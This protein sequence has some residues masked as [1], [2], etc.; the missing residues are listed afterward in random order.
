MQNRKK[1]VIIAQRYGITP[2][3]FGGAVESLIGSL[4]E[5]N[6]IHHAIDLTIIQSYNA[7]A[8]ELTKKFKDTKFVFLRDSILGKLD[9]RIFGQRKNEEFMKGQIFSEY[10]YKSYGYIKK[11]SPMWMLLFLKKTVKSSAIKNFR[12]NFP[13]KSPI[14]VI[15]MKNPKR[16]SIMT[17]LYL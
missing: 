5:N 3:I 10:I 11:I 12:D 1:V 16:I 2:A 13:E 14:T 7:K 6:E 4:A 15:Y 17:M 8:R 9:F